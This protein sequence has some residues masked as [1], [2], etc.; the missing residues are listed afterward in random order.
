MAAVER[1]PSSE[2]S[3]G[4]RAKTVTASDPLLQHSS[5]RCEG[6]RRKYLGV[7]PPEGSRCRKRSAPLSASMEKTVMESSPR[8][9]AYKNLPSAAMTSC[10]A[11]SPAP[12]AAPASVELSG[13]RGSSCAEVPCSTHRY[14]C[15][16][17]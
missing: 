8:L 1:G 6:S 3:W 16:V 4:L 15:S 5:Q 2:P 9:L 14:C 12:E 10:A 11:A 13:P 17:E 7:L